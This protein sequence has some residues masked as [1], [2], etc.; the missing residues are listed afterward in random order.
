MT[1]K[2]VYCQPYQITRYGTYENFDCLEVKKCVFIWIM[3]SNRVPLICLKSYLHP[4]FDQLTWLKRVNFRFFFWYIFTVL[5]LR[6]QS[7]EKNLLE[8]SRFNL[9][10]GF[11]GVL[12]MHSGKLKMRFLPTAPIHIV[13]YVPTF[14]VCKILVNVFSFVVWSTFVFLLIV[15]KA[16]ST[17][18]SINLFDC[19]LLHIRFLSVILTWSLF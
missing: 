16:I 10:K 5:I 13:C 4:N 2:S 7:F 17:Q 6:S 18:I 11:G 1:W 14:F 19:S 3:I 8:I 15:S 9:S 12:K